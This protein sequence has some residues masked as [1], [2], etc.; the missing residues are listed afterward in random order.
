MRELDLLDGR[1]PPLEVL[2]AVKE[3]RVLPQR[4]CDRAQTPDVLRMSP[5]GVVTPAVAVRDEGSPH[6]GRAATL[7]DAGGGRQ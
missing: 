4:P 3:L 1:V 6:R 2:D 5:T 7:P